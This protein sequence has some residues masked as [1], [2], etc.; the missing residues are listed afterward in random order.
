M[1]VTAVRSAASYHRLSRGRDWL[2]ARQPAEEILIIGTTPG[3]ANELARGLAQEKRASFGYHRLTWGQ[4]ASALARP[5]LAAQRIAPLGALGIQAAANRAIHSLS[6]LGVLGR[7]A[8]LTDGPGFARAIADIITELR[9]EQ[10]E[11]GA[12]AEVVPDLRSLLETYEQELAD[13][14]F[15]DRPGVLCVAGLGTEIVDLDSRDA[16][17]PSS[18]KK[19]MDHRYAFNNTISVMRRLHLRRN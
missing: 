12:L 7:Y 1:A 3:A 5:A 9:L 17:Q 6:K 16:S 8:K 4:L 2:S 18:S 10:V 11:P 13:H 14:G 19:R 15:T